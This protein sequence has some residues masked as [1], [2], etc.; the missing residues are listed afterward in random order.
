MKRR[1]SSS[2]VHFLEFKKFI[3]AEIHRK[4]FKVVFQQLHIV[5]ELAHSASVQ[6]G[7]AYKDIIDLFRFVKTLCLFQID[8]AEVVADRFNQFSI[9]PS[10]STETSSTLRMAQRA[11]TIVILSPPTIRVMVSSLMLEMVP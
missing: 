11:T 10:F 4:I 2:A 7:S 5:H 1:I 8:P 6:I 9:S 3:C